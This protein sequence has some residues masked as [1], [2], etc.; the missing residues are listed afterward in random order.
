MLRINGSWGCSA[1]LRRCSAPQQIGSS[2]HH[3]DS[4]DFLLYLFRLLKHLSTMVTKPKTS[5]KIT[6]SVPR[7]QSVV[8]STLSV[9]T[10]PIF[11]SN[12]NSPFWSK[13]NNSLLH[14]RFCQDCSHSGSLRNGMMK[15][16]VLQHDLWSAM[17]LIFTN[18]VTPASCKV[19][20]LIC[21]NWTCI[22]GKGIVQHPLWGL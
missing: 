22:Q 14:L 20:Y 12:I 2:V 8:F 9:I 6:G 18:V 1:P 17:R 11:K 16:F 4:T 13:F 10:A 19:Q 5:I 7:G 21:K 15:T 3:Q